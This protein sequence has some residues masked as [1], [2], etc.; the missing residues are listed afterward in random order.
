MSRKKGKNQIVQTQQ[1]SWGAFGVELHDVNKCKKELRKCYGVDTYWQTSDYNTRLFMMFRAQ[2]LGMA[3]SRFKW[4]NLPK[5]CD[6]RFLEMTLILQGCAS[7]AFPKKQRG[8]FYS[9]QCAQLGRPNIYDNPVAWRAIG[10]NGFNFSADWKQGVVVWDNRARYPLL[11]KINIWAREL[12][13]IIRTKQLNRQHQKIP[14]I[15]KVPQEMQDQAANIYK[16]V[17]GGEP[18]ILGTSGLE[19]FQPDVW[20]TGVQFIGEELTAEE[21]NIW[22]EIYLA[23][24]IAHQTYKNER[25][26]EDEVRSQKEPSEFVRLD[27]LNCRREACKKLNDRFSEYLDKPIQ[28][29]WDYDNPSENYNYSQN[30]KEQVD[31]EDKQFG[32]VEEME[33]M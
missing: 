10:N 4:L 15:F 20:N 31:A 27:S 17:A 22:N 25:M 24:G 32:K 33:G 9:T 16:Q 23:L 19:T 30:V 21:E 18:A 14:Y 7:I 3:L 5:T 1:T 29:I 11:E 13:D 6:T 2:I 26:I 12:V 28:V 8:V